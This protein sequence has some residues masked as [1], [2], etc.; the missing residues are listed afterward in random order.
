MK[1]DYDSGVHEDVTFFIG[2]EVEHTPA[3]GM[4]TLFVVGVHDE[5]V[6]ITLAKN[7]N[8][9]HIYFGA[10]QS[11]GTDGVNDIGTWRPWEDMIKG[12]LDADFWCT[13]DFDVSEAEGLLES[14]LTENRR[15]IPQ[16]SVKLPYLTQLG[17]NATIKIDDKDFD[18][19]NP[20]VWCLPLSACTQRK[21]FTNWDCY[22]QDEIIK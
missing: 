16:I 5:Q 8:C 7:N 21:Y 2:T 9:N 20:G 15:F 18:A 12:C 13:L 10:N 6:I 1:R 19:T 3:Y 4:K 17:Y 22:T 14:G 11:F